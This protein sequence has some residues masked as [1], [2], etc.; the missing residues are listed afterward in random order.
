MKIVIVGA[1]TLIGEHIATVVSRET[2]AELVLISIEEKQA[3]FLPKM[4]WI[5][6]D[7]LDKKSIKKIILESKADA[8]VN[9]ITTGAG[10]DS[11]INK[12]EIW[13]TNV[14]LN[15]A[16]VSAAK[17]LEAH[18]ITFSSEE[19]FLGL[20]GPE[21]EQS[22]V[23][24]VN[25]FAKSMLARENTTIVEHAKSTIFRITEPFGTSSFEKMDVVSKY[26]LLLETGIDF[27][28]QTNHYSNPVFVLDIGN[29][30][31]I[32][33]ERQKYG[34]YNLG[35]TDYVSRHEMVSLI[36]KTYGFEHDLAVPAES[37]K[38]IKLGLSTLK[39]ETDL[40]LNF[41]GFENALIAMKYNSEGVPGLK[42]I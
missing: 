3:D 29:A 5:K 40:R 37:E 24:A 31:A 28:V 1:D 34:T 17:I 42:Y 36:A 16:L 27:E 6:V 14:N 26:F 20:S 18:L 22:T 8:I 21:T 2:D 19:L 13:E 39:A 38:T 10:D 30:V 32:A 33:L 25:Y 4:N 12:S 7:N 41:T 11:D 15:S 9:C 35:G 23:N